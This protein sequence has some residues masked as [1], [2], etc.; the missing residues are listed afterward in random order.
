LILNETVTVS[1]NRSC[2]Q[3][4]SRFSFFHSFIVAKGMVDTGRGVGR[5]QSDK[6]KESKLPKNHKLE[7]VF[8]GHLSSKSLFSTFSTS[9][10][11]CLCES[12]DNPLWQFQHRQLNYGYR[13]CETM[14]EALLSLFYFHNEFVNIWL[15][16]IGTLLLLWKTYRYYLAYSPQISTLSLEYQYDFLVLFICIIMGNCFPILTSGL[17]HHFYCINQSI[18]KLCW[19][20]DFLGMLSGITFVSSNFLYLTF[21]CDHHP[22]HQSLL[23]YHSSSG[24][25]SSSSAASIPPVSPV[26]LLTTFST[27][28][29]IITVLVGGYVIAMYLCWKRYQERLSKNELLPKDRFPEFSSTLSGYSGFVYFVSLG[30]SIVFVSEYLSHPTL[31]SIFLQSCLYPL[32]MAMG[33]VIFAQGSIPEKYHTIFGVSPHFFDFLGHSHQLWHI[34]SLAVLYFWIDVIFQH[35]EVRY[36]MGC[37]FNF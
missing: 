20:L 12:D 14:Y 15:H 36:N 35:Y 6:I 5:N 9:S 22:N 34:V 17:C 16:Y 29:Y 26:T 8:L 31:N 27:F 32:A 3:N 21:Y 28:H 2:F 24:L 1:Y 18:H 13:T 7:D 23:S 30:G 11:Y 10:T 19:Y 25:S 33:I 37:P 4:F